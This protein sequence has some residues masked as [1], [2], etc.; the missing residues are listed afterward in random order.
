ML[1]ITIQN[2]FRLSTGL[3]ERLRFNGINRT[4][5]MQ[6]PDVQ[7]SEV[8]EST[9]DAASSPAARP[10][11]TGGRSAPQAQHAPPRHIE[12]LSPNTV[13][14]RDDTDIGGPLVVKTDDPDLN[15]PQVPIDPFP[16]ERTPE[17]DLPVP[18]RND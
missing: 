2:A 12:P 10:E 13:I 17:V 7:K 16:T 11:S 9:E 6:D 4:V 3:P 14:L 18:S 15:P 5:Y 8:H 1:R